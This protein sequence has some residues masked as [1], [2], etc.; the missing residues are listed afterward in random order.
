MAGGCEEIVAG[1][2]GDQLT[3][4]AGAQCGAPTHGDAGRSDGRR[5]PRAFIIIRGW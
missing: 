1:G 3:L 5:A 4:A 2:S